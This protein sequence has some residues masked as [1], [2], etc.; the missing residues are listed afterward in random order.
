MAELR[1]VKLVR[2]DVEKFC[3][4]LEI[5]YED[6]QE[7]EGHAAFV[8][9][10]HKKL[11]EEVTEYLLDQTVDE[12]ADILEAVEFIASHVHGGMAELHRAQLAKRAKKGSFLDGLGMYLNVAPEY[13]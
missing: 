8:G 11:G 7:V 6:I 4:N 10:L 12:L 2:D 9:A 3:G 1:L 13:Q 5:R